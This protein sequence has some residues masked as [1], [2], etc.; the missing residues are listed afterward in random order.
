MQH[1]LAVE[2]F[3]AALAGA[4]GVM[5]GPAVQRAVHVIGSVYALLAHAGVISTSAL[6]DDVKFCIRIFWPRQ[7]TTQLPHSNMIRP[8][9]SEMEKVEDRRKERYIHYAKEDTQ[10]IRDILKHLGFWRVK[11]RPPPK[12]HDPPIKADSDQ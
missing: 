2:G 5:A 7:A 8:K 12:I 3:V 6:A 10:V 11:S 9:E 4:N 1:R